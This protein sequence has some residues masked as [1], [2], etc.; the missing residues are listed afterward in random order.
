MQIVTDSGTDIGLTPREM[1][2]LNI[3]VVP[4]VVTLNGRSYREG[5]DIETDAFYEKLD[6]SINMP[7]TSPPTARD[8]AELYRTLAKT[9]RQILSVH[10]TMG[11]SL[12]AQIR[13]SGR[14]DGA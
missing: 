8:F 11:L 10:M 12:Y 6:A 4:L 5:L 7:V 9:D 3:H 14:I 13:T 2:E 1:K